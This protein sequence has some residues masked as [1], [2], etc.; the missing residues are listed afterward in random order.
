MP[1]PCGRFINRAVYFPGVF[2]PGVGSTASWV[3]G[4]GIPPASAG[5]FWGVLARNDQKPLAEAM[6][7]TR[8][9][10]MRAVHQSGG[11]FSGRFHSGR[12]LNGVVGD[13]AR[14]PT[15]F[16]R[17]LLGGR[18][19]DARGAVTPEAPRGSDRG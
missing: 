18:A 19:R 17:G 15:G 1:S 8:A 11:L 7:M 16:R 14:H 2:I 6:G 9:I 12:W 4:R 3:M 13:G 10:T 5:G